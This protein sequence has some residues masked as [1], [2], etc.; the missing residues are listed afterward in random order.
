[1]DYCSPIWSP[2]QQKEIKE[3]E[4]I[5]REFTRRIAGMKDLD[6]WE[7]LTYLNLYSQERRRERYSIIFVWKISVGLTKGYN[8]PFD[9]NPRRGKF[10]R[11]KH[12]VNQSP[13]SVKKAQEASL[14]VRGAKLFNLL[15]QPLRNFNSEKVDGFKRRLDQFLKSIPD[16][17]SIQGRGRGAETNSLLHQLP[18]AVQQNIMG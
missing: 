11:V 6:Y 7:R 4:D 17:P 15:P 3:L 9:V 10:A 12:I 1:M 5:Q 18:W 16:Q 14:S 8:I 2:I 13:M